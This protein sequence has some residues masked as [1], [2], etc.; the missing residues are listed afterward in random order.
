MKNRIKIY[1][2][3]T[4]LGEEYR[5]LS[6]EHLNKE[7]FF[8]NY[9]K[10]K[11]E[12]D[13]DFLK[14]ILPYLSTFVMIILTLMISLSNSTSYLNN[15]QMSYFI[16]IWSSNNIAIVKMDKPIDNDNNVILK[17]VTEKYID[18][19][20]KTGDFILD[21]NI[22]IFK[23]GMVLVTFAFMTIFLYILIKYAYIINKLFEYDLR[24]EIVEDFL[25]GRN[26][27]QQT[28]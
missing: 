26:K 2:K 5:W 20:E 10:A 19:L 8:L 15:K 6:Q 4:A 9:S 11:Q 27:R 3:I 1:K 23:N 18:I 28:V 25:S 14:G 17:E 22:K 21:R 13:L 12:K 16:D 7:R 24:L